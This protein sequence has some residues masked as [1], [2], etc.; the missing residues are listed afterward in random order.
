M[1]ARRHR[2]P[3]GGYRWGEH[4]TVRLA[5]ERVATVLI[6]VTADDSASWWG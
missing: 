5:V 1:S 6:M 2:G 3:P 4:H